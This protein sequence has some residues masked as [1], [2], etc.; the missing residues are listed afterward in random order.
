M[1]DRL[2]PR[3]FNRRDVLQVLGAGAGLGAAR[4]LPWNAETLSAAQNVF[5]SVHAVNVPKGAVIR[6]ILKDVSPDAFVNGGTLVHEHLS[7]D[8]ELMVE[9]LKAAHDDGL[10]GLVALTTDRRTDDQ[11]QK[12]QGIAAKSPVQIILEEAI[13]RT[14][15]LIKTRP[16]SR[17]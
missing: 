3:Q 5:K 9:E 12:N 15:G 1:S 10:G 11:V 2:P 17:G 6:T 13:S 7:V 4:M 14:L 16:A 8:V